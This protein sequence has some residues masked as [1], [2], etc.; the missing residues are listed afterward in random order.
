ME[1]FKYG[2][3]F[4]V[5]KIAARL[6]RKVLDVTHVRPKRRRFRRV[7]KASI[8]KH[9]AVRTPPPPLR[10]MKPLFSLP[11]KNSFSVLSF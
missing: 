7:R 8:P 5:Q 9:I 1:C 3:D 10:V 2:F 6:S 4:D 11:L